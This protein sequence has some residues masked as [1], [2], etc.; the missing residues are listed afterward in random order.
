MKLSGASVHESHEL[1][2]EIKAP[3]DYTRIA[4]WFLSYYYLARQANPI[5][6]ANNASDQ[7]IRNNNKTALRRPIIATVMHLVVVQNY[8]YFKHTFGEDDG[9]TYPPPGHT[10]MR[11]RS[12]GSFSK[13]LCRA[14]L[15]DAIGNSLTTSS[16]ESQLAQ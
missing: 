14:S 3:R 13:P 9:K 7:S 6:I 1:L 8:S 12:K 10:I 4:I 5:S 2:R 15:L 11:A 16:S